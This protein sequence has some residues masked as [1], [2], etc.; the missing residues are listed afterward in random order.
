MDKEKINLIFDKS[1][2]KIEE[3]RKIFDI[4]ID[5][6]I[7]I[8]KDFFDNECYNFT[9]NI[10]DNSNKVC[11][12]HF[13]HHD[14]QKYFLEQIKKYFEELDNKIQVEIV[15]EN[16]YP[17]DFGIFLNGYYV[18]KFNIYYHTFTST[19]KDFINPY[20]I[21]HLLS[22][23]EEYIKERDE[24]KRYIENPKT[25]INDYDYKNKLLKVRDMICFPFFKDKMVKACK[26]KLPKAEEKLL[27]I[28]KKIKR[29]E[30]KYAKYELIK[31][32][33]KKSYEFWEDKFINEYGYELEQSNYSSYSYELAKKVGRKDIFN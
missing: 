15:D 12:F 25:I 30:E 9:T 31:E 27:E 5:N 10:I 29:I 19:N 11:D 13:S 7:Y 6:P 18:A 3:S 26:E 22:E 33:L 8:L 16:M 17:S 21:E 4:M 2:E 20:N 28:D 14:L 1:I 32:D 24:Y 23:K